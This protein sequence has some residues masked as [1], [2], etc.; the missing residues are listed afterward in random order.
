MDFIGLPRLERLILY[1]STAR[2]VLGVLH[3]REMLIA[4]LREEISR[5]EEKRQ[6]LRWGSKILLSLIAAR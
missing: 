6:A 1:C 4:F 3:K 5:E 2:V